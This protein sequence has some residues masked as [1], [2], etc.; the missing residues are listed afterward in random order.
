MFGKLVELDKRFEDIEAEMMKAEVISNMDEY[1][2]LA[3]ERTDLKEVVDA[4]REWKDTKAEYERTSELLKQ[5]ADEE[6]KE[7]ARE[8][9]DK[10]EK[11][12]AG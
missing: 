6:M 8:E 3:K 5:E 11:K 7:L 1:K 12:M 10:L 9:L 2:K 4:Y